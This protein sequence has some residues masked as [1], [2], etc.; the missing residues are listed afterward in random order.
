[1]TMA[2]KK[3]TPVITHTELLCYAAN[4]LNQDIRHWEEACA[5]MPNGEVNAALICE[6]QI[7]QLN[8]I[9]QMY[10]LETGTEM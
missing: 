10:L 8:A 9:R 7:N 5:D 6:R 2:K 1:M 4:W 3:P